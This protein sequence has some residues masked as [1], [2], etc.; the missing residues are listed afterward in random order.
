MG[1]DSEIAEYENGGAP[2]MYQDLYGES[3]GMSN[4]YEL[5]RE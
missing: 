2:R 1:G 3:E 4:I 5:V